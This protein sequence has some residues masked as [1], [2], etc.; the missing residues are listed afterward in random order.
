[1]NRASDPASAGGPEFAPPAGWAVRGLAAVVAAATTLRLWLGHRYFGFSSGD[2]VEILEIGFWRVFGVDHQPLE[3]RSPLVGDLLVSPILAAASGLGVEAPRTLSW[4][5]TFP[6]VALASLNVVLVFAL[7]RRWLRGD[8][9]ALL[10]STI[11]AFHWIPLGYGST[12]YPR[13]ASTTCVL[14][15]VWLVSGGRR[16]VRLAA[17]GALVGLAFSLRY[18]EG[19][20][21]LPFVVL[22]AL[23]VSGWGR[24]FR[25]ALW[26][27]AGFLLM[28]LLS[29]GVAE[30][31]YWGRPFAGFRAMWRFAVVEGQTTAAVTGDG[32]WW[33][34]R[35]LPRW[36]PPTLLPFLLAGSRRGVP[37]QAVPFLLLPLA[38]LSAL[39]G[40]QLR[41]LQAVIPFLA[42]AA[43]GAATAWWATG[44]RR[45][46][47]VLVG[48]SLLLGLNGLTFLQKKS[49]AAVLAAEALAEDPSL[50]CVA[51]SQPWA[52]APKIYLPGS[53]EV[54][55]LPFA[56][57]AADLERLT[58]GCGILGLYAERL[59]DAPELAHWIERH[60]FAPR[61]TYRWGRSREVFLFE[62]AGGLPRTP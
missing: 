18:S 22:L 45:S 39:P 60:G 56:P 27:G 21:L 43:A 25:D 38:V 15:A 34:L 36:L 31:L 28:V 29:S 2:D 30:W 26:V 47:A 12:V 32:G 11:Y 48:L 6:F 35:R 52:Y 14:A 42:L 7:G 24:R 4:M 53:I 8:G 54:R 62:R 40:P 58:P 59:A 23:G 13:T 61:A 41:F 57:E 20:Y 49:M 16:P 3:V 5:A 51:L 10:A 55:R 9:A 44:R 33:F 50:S 1:M 17:G 37:W 46:A 19:L